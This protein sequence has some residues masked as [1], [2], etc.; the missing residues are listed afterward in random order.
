MQASPPLRRIGLIVDGWPPPEWQVRLMDELAGKAEVSVYSLPQPQEE[1]ET[2]RRLREKVPC[3]RRKQCHVQVRHVDNSHAALARCHEAQVDLVVDGTGLAARGRYSFRHGLWSLRQGN[4]LGVGAP[5]A[6]LEEIASREPAPS[7]ALVCNEDQV[8]RSV[9]PQVARGRYVAGLDRL[10]GI[11]AL[12]P[13]AMCMMGE[14]PT[15]AWLPSP[16]VRSLSPRAAL[17]YAAWLSAR[18]RCRGW[19]VSDSW[20]LGIIDKP[21]HKVCSADLEDEVRWLGPWEHGRYWADPFGVPG[22][23][24][25]LLCEEVMHDRPTGVL[26]ELTVDGD[27]ITA[28]RKVVMSVG[29]HLSYPFLFEHEGA[30]WCIPESGEAGKVVLHRLDPDTREWQ[31]SCTALSGVC[32]ADPTLFA[33]RGLLWIAYSDAKFGVHDSL[34]LAWAEHITGPWRPH[35]LNPVKIDVRSARPAGTPF[36]RNGHLIRPAQDCSRTYGGAIA[37]NRIDICTPEAYAEETIEFIRSSPRIRHPLGPHTLSAWGERTLVDCKR[38]W[39]NPAVIHYKIRKR[40]GL[41]G[42]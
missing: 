30:N 19:M 32:A 2:W 31:P 9:H 35:P 6:F 23:P 16:S 3:L 7:I 41:V 38:E 37:L 12:L 27:R 10:L 15:R 1:P 20:M 13:S 18:D 34:C 8:V 39:M 42:H 11:A 5:Y 17:G 26:K 14:E 22:D 36:I 24:T 25:R 33:H 28:E 21:I 4:G 40:L 29:G